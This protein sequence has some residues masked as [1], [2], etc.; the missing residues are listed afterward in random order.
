MHQ[1]ITAEIADNT[2]Y[3]DNFANDGQRFVAWYLHRV[4]QLDVHATKAAI[5]DGQHDKQIDAIVVEDGEDRRIRVIQG[6]FVKPEPID[7]TPLREVTMAWTR[8]KNLPKLQLECSG[9]LAE[10][11]EAMRVALEDDYEV[12]FELLTTGSLTPAAATDFDACKAAMNDDADF[13]ASLTLV[14]SA[15]LET[16][17][18]EAEQRDLPELSCEIELDPERFLMSTETNVRVILAMLPIERCLKLPGIADGKLFRRNVRQSLGLS[19]K[20]NKELRNTLASSEK[21]PYFFFFHNGITALCKRFTLSSDRR[22]LKVDALSVVNGCQSLS[23]IYATSGKVAQKGGPQGSVLFRFYEI[24]QHDLG[25]AISINTNSQSAVKPRDL[26][27]NDKYMRSIKRRYESGVSG[28]YFLTK[29]GEERPPDKDPAKCVDATEYARMVVSWQCQRP[30]LASNEKRLFDEHYKTLFHSDLDPQSILALRLW[31]GEIDKNWAQLDINEAVK[32]VRGAARFHLLFVV[33]QLVAHASKQADKVP[34]PA[35][36]MGALQFAPMV[37]A[38]AKECIN[39]ALQQA[40]TQAATAN[41]VFSPQNWLKGKSAVSDEQ[42]VAG[43]IVNVLRGVGGPA[44]APV[45]ASLTVPADKFSF[46][47]S[48]E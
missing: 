47:W 31:L 5:T 13:S 27:S 17:L 42:L 36:T 39:Q 1:Q 18:S 46:R 10:R 28:G 26:R 4:L 14:D 23:T 19:N 9:R 25:D 41:K 22:H 32:A 7:A 16:R 33:S 43:T 48:A 29:R 21:A 2:F 37:L 20:V 3:R 45:L 44:L 11:L 34:L 6:K 40:V 8:L 30:N 12:H 38:Q 15:L 35:S 24:P